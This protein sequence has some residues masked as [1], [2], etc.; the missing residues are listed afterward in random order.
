M[1]IPVPCE[2]NP[3]SVVKQKGS[4]GPN[5][6]LLWVCREEPVLVFVYQSKI[7]I[8]RLKYLYPAA[9]FRNTM[10]CSLSEDKTG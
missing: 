6:A 8:R 7:A 10:P 4:S 3:P 9:Q 1:L 5:F 2:I